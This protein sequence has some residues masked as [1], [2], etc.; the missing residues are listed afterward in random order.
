MDGQI[1]FGIGNH[2]GC[3]VIRFKGDLALGGSSGNIISLKQGL[4]EAGLQV[5]AELWDWYKENL[6]TYGKQKSGGTVG[7]T[8]T[9]GDAS[10]N[11]IPTAAKTQKV[12]AAV[13]VLSRS[14]GEGID[15]TI[16]NG[17]KSDFGDGNYLKLSHTERNVL[18]ILKR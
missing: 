15:S 17:D 13:F 7:T 10:W 1:L 4:E 9:I 3:R 14:G 11:Q 16:Y 8:W 5:N 18:K 12:D 6:G 2:I